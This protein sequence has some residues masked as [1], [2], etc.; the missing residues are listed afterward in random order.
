[1]SIALTA[2]QYLTMMVLRGN[3]IVG[4]NILDNPVDPFPQDTISKPTIAIYIGDDT[5]EDVDTLGLFGAPHTV[6][7]SIQTYLPASVTIEADGKRHKISARGNGL[8]F[9][10][11]QIGAQI[12]LQLATGQSEA[13][14]LWRELIGGQPKKVTTTP[15]LME[16]KTK[17][18][19]G[20][21]IPAVERLLVVQTCADP[22]FEPDDIPEF[23]L[24]VLALF[25]ADEEFE[26]IAHLIRT[27][28]TGLGDAPAW[29]IAQAQLGL[30]EQAAAALGIGPVVIDET[31]VLDEIEFDRGGG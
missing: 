17:G 1:M 2:L 29:R 26:P 15:W 19:G 4:D 24:R 23:W 12:D 10:L 5:R 22:L 16:V 18:G 9:I 3:T 6:E 14:I 28:A 7:L 31:P 8:Q 20:L 25:E 11:G 21:R 27:M 30:T 13:A